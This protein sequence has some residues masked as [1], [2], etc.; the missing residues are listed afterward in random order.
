[1]KAQIQILTSDN[2]ETINIDEVNNPNHLTYHDSYGAFNELTIYEDGIEILRSSA[3][4][5]TEFKLRNNDKS[6]I[7]I[8][9]LEG[10]IVFDAKLLAFERNND[11]ITLVYNVNNDKNTIVIKFTGVILCQQNQ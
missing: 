8:Q 4:H 1:M 2:K 7:S 3:S 9:S 11:I 10:K 6:F 5:N